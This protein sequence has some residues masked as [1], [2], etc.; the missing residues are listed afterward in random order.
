MSAPEVC[1]KLVEAINSGKYDLAVVNFANCD[2]VGHTGVLEAAVKAVEIV[3]E[4]AGKVLEAVKS[5]GG[6]M[7]LTA[8]HGK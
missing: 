3:D 7:I 6:A 2:M 5:Q 8:D 4:C 1:D